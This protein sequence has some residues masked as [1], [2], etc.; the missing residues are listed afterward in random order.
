[1]SNMEEVA[2]Q[3]AYYTE[4][5]SKYDELHANEYESIRLASGVLHGT[6]ELINARS[7]LD[8]GCGTGT[9]M[10]EVITR[11]PNMNVTGIEPVA[12]LRNLAIAKGLAEQQVVLGDAASMQFSARSFDVVCAFSVLHHVP[13]PT[14]VISEMLRVATKAIVICDSNNFGQGS[15]VSRFS[16]QL[17]HSAGLWPLVNWLKTGG[18]GYSFTEGDGVAYSYSVFSNLQQ[19]KGACKAVHVLGMGASSGNLY[20]DSGS[21]VIVGVL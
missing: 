3:R 1:V 19:I 10:R 5:A 6:F 20:R 11:H 18:R 13:Q 21:I 12:A 8:V 14:A 16:K 7:L 9:L 17:L 15:P 4:T 2:R